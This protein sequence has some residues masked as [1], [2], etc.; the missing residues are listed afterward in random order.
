MSS[1][2]HVL[3]SRATLFAS[4]VLPALIFRALVPAG[5][6]P[7]RDER[8]ELAIM[9]CTGGDPHAHHA[10]PMAG[11]GHSG[12]GHAAGH[13]LCPFA[14]SAGPALGWVNSP[15]EPAGVVVATIERAQSARAPPF[16]LR[17]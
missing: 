8:G 14:L 12:S 16:L 6:M 5:F 17:V 13:G 1:P 7:M 2:S 9:R 15:G 4:L 11:G 3:R 10:Q